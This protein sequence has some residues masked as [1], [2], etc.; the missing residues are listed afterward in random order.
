MQLLRMF[1]HD[2]YKGCELY[3]KSQKKYEI[4]RTV[5]YF[6]ISLSLFIA[7][8]IA[9]GE[10]MNLLTVVAILGCLPA[11]KSAV[12]MI[13]FLRFQ[14][15]SEASVKTIKEHMEGLCGLYDMIFTS[16]NRNYNIAH[17]TVKGNT[18]CGFTEDKKFAE[19]EFYKH[20]TDILK[21]DHFKE[22]S[23]K[24]YSDLNKYTERLEQL[25]N[26]DADTG[27]TEGI[28]STLKSVSL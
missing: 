5:L 19:Q 2:N 11:S 23:V 6:G 28:L 16:Y 21:V 7:G 1:T 8:F 18:I 25:K 10:R 3:L 26:L 22:T 27:N 14:G 15:C 17:I 9:T 20:I 24:I 12:D 4:M 13:M